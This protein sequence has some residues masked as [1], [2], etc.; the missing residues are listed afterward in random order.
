MYKKNIIYIAIND[1][2]LIAI[3]DSLAFLWYFR[4]Y[5]IV[6]FRSLNQELLQ[7]LRLSMFSHG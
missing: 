5:Q 6:K 1:A 7:K 3:I 2:E 4:S